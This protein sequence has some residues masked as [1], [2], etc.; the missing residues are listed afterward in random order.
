MRYGILLVLALASA[1]CANQREVD[2]FYRRWLEPKSERQ[3]RYDEDLPGYTTLYHR[4]LF[5][6]L[7][8]G[9]PEAEVLLEDR[10]TP[11][12]YVVRDRAGPQGYDLASVDEDTIEGYL[13]SRAGYIIIRRPAARTLWI[14]HSS[15]E[16]GWRLL[17]ED[18]P[19][20][21]P[22]TVTGVDP[23]GWTYRSDDLIAIVDYLETADF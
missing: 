15:S 11:L 7:R 19:P 9:T 10:K 18:V 3:V 13:A 16:A 22:V 21:E 2:R 20:E 4:E 14:F 8:S 17:D 1:A 12:H 6:V 5:W 23:D